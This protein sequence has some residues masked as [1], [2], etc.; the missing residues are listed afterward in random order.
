MNGVR[1]SLWPMAYRALQICNKEHKTNR[2]T[3]VS[4]VKGAFPPVGYKINSHIK[5][6]GDKIPIDGDIS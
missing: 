4:L 2:L 6:K 3:A 1:E 5:M